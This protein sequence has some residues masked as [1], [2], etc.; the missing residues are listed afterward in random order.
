MQGVFLFQVPILPLAQKVFTLQNLFQQEILLL[1]L[2]Q[3]LI[4][5]YAINQNATQLFEAIDDTL[6]AYIDRAIQTLDITIYD[7]NL[8][9]ISNIS[10]AIN[11]AYNRGVDVRVISDGSL[12]A[13]NT[14]ITAISSS[15]IK[16]PSPTGSNYGIMHN[17][18]VIIDAYHSNPK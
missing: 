12:A 2:I 13:T 7:F 3:V 1:I 9:N 4:I 5:R 17:K 6:I 18:F 10:N 8:T 11:A 14:G 15:I 16:I